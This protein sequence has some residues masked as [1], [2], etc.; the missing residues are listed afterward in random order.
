MIPS[1]SDPRWRALVQGTD[2]LELKGLAARMLVT[3][4]R[5]MGARKDEV[6]LKAAIETA[7]DFFAK[8]TEAARD[9]IRV[10]FG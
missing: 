6:S 8:N 10:I 4:V 5:L 2:K 1:K 7:Y 9:D 3:R